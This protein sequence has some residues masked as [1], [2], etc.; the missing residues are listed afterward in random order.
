MGKLRDDII[1]AV[2]ENRDS[3]PAAS[4][5]DA[6]GARGDAEGQD[7]RHVAEFNKH[8]ATIEGL[9]ENSTGPKAMA[10]RQAIGSLTMAM[11][12]ECDELGQ[13]ND[14]LHREVK[15]LRS[16]VDYWQEQGSDAANQRHKERMEQGERKLAMSERLLKPRRI[17]RDANGRFTGLES[18]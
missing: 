18:V 9:L 10:L 4:G 6:N 3:E 17:T 5:K 2:E 12:E 1:D 15:S 16:Q 11:L 7:S 14:K 8:M 13:E